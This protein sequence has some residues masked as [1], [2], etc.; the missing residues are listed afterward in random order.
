LAVPVVC[1]LFIVGCENPFAPNLDYNHS[2]ST[3]G[4]AD[5]RY[6]DGIFTNMAYAYAFKDTLI[7]GQILNKDFTFTYRDYDLGYDVSW[8]RQEEMRITENMF[9]NSEQLSLV[10]NKILQDSLQ[11]DSTQIIRG[12]NLS[13]IFNPSDVVRIDGR[14]SLT[15]QKDSASGKWSILKWNDESNF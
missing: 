6:V 2:G 3:T 5:L 8:G 14:V 15:L 4:I 7:Y 10:W 12:F 1:L 11:Q 9:Q 13:V